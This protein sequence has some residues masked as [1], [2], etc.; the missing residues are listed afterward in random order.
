[1]A[2]TKLGYGRAVKICNI[3]ECPDCVLRHRDR[4]YH[5]EVH[6]RENRVELTNEF[7][8]GPESNC[9]AGRWAG[10]KPMDIP[11][12]G[13]QQHDAFVAESARQVTAYLK[14]FGATIPEK[15]TD[16]ATELTQLVAEGMLNP[17]VAAKIEENLLV[18]KETHTIE[19]RTP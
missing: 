16:I 6:G 3:R 7:R 4:R 9:P 1:M 2:I 15:Q 12:I 14:A 11:A 13:E 10:V 8:S 17:E 5:C 19:P 18:E